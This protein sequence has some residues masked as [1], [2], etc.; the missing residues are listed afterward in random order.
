[1]SGF[2]A[3]TARLA[4]HSIVSERQQNSSYNSQGLGKKKLNMYRVFL[5]KTSHVLT[6][7]VSRSCAL[8]VLLLLDR[9]AT[10]YSTQNNTQPTTH[11]HTHTPVIVPL[12]NTA[13][14]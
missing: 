6:P 7:E 4:T 5:F 13:Q 9:E 1:M 14:Y 2:N 8:P 11:T 12:R 3:I 10:P